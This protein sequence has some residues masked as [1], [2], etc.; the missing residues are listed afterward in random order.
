M[1]PLLVRMKGEIAISEDKV[2]KR[3][4][5][6]DLTSIPKPL[7]PV[8]ITTFLMRASFYL[9]L[10]VLNYPYYLTHLDQWH[11]SL[12]FIVYPL[13]ELLTVMFFGILSDKVG[14]KII[15]YVGLGLTGFAVFLFAFFHSFVS[16]IFVS[17][18][19]GIGAAAQVASTLAM[20]ADLSPD[21]K[22][23]RFMGFYDAM[24]LLGLGLGFGLGFLVMEIFFGK[25][26]QNSVPLDRVSQVAFWMFIIGAFITLLSLIIA[27]L[28]LKG[29]IFRSVEAQRI[30][31][32]E[33]V[34]FIIKDKALKYLLPVWVPIIC[35]YAIVLT[36]AED[37][38]HQL[39]LH[40]IK[41]LLV[42]AIIFGSILIGFPLNGILSDKI[43]RK[44]FLYFGMFSFAAFVSLLAF[45]A[46]KSSPGNYNMLFYLSP[47][48][49][50]FGIGCGAFPP[51]ALALLSELSPKENYGTSMGAY[52][53]VYGTGM[54]IG[55]LLASLSRTIGVKIKI[56][57]IW[58][59][60]ILVWILC[61]ISIIGTLLLPKTLLVKVKK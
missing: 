40:D 28:V 30:P 10:S 1:Q 9:S 37:L 58:G 55:P 38:A 29:T 27:I 39:N 25:Y 36:N 44:P 6:R 4:L 53:V 11:K 42:L 22:R 13:A 46:N 61:V 16:L 56:G 19:F 2:Q 34:K 49:L 48:L 33:R 26:D 12:I 14:R 43:G 20:V 24:T 54:I 5:L 17:I 45:G 41:L 35:L 18:L 50:I 3:S 32:R 59:L 7:I 23:G 31:L 57:D 47:A 60:I 51:A 52:S 21:D 15:F 8:Y